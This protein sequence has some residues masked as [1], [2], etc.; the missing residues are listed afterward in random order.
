MSKVEESESDNGKYPDFEKNA[1][2]TKVLRYSSLSFVL[3]SSDAFLLCLETKKEQ[4]QEGKY[5][6]FFF[7]I[8][9]ETTIA[10][11][12]YWNLSTGETSYFLF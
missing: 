11:T 5:L 9:V 6:F 7:E 10:S 1:N 12:L 2:S 3:W 8:Q 4:R